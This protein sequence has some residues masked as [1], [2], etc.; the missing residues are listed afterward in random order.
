MTKSSPIPRMLDPQ[1]VADTLGVSLRT[2]RRFIKAEQITVHRI[3]RQIRISEHDLEQ[4][5][6]LRRET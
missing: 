5:I 3:G 2:V 4:F 1:T 6:R